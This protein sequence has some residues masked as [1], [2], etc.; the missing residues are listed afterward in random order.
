ML[1]V[2]RVAGREGDALTLLARDPYE[3]VFIT[4][5]LLF[6]ASPTTLD[7]I[8][9]ALDAANHVRGVAYFARQVVVVGDREAIDTFAQL[10]RSMR[11]ERM[12]VGRRESVEI[13]WERVRAWH[14]APRHIRNHQPLLVL[15][16]AS[17]NRCAQHVTVRRA[18]MDEWPSVADS[19]AQMTQQELEYDPR[20]TW[21]Q[22]TANVRKMIEREL[23]WVGESLGRL[24]F[25]C[26]VGPWSAQTMQL[27][28]IW[29][30]PELRG[31]GLATAA[32][33]AICDRL[34]N[35]SPTLS[36]Y[37]NDY[38][39]PAINLYRRIGFT[40]VSEFQT[41]LF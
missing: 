3:N 7:S 35:T 13:Y 5:L 4:Y 8:F 18:R 34:L 41:L 31:K 30:P 12:I 26:N 32:M 1:R 39:T 2:E 6:S 20:Q 22:F 37:V 24:C 15:D 29:T 14:P 19:S 23:W 36:L 27:Q 11:G 33:S 17:L 21:P 28:G 9:V 38:N 16:R 25:F 10:A 40:V